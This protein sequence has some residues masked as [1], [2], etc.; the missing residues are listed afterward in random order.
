M[1][2][3]AEKVTIDR[4]RKVVLIDGE[5]FPY[6]LAEEGPSVENPLDRHSPPVISLPLIA[7][8]VEIIPE[9]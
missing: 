8:D 9:S 6:F 1:A 5:E 7:N 4:K 2:K 3:F